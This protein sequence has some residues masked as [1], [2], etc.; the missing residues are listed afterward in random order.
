[1]VLASFYLDIL[2][3]EVLVSAD[4]CTS[5]NVLQWEVL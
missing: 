3:S 1:M 4:R 5:R 2:F